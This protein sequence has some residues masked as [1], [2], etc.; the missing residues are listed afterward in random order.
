MVFYSLIFC[1]IDLLS[2]GLLLFNLLVYLSWNCNNQKE[3]KN[4]CPQN[5]FT[6]E[7][8]YKLESGFHYQSFWFICCY[9]VHPTPSI[10]KCSRLPMSLFLVI[11]SRLAWYSPRITS[12]APKSPVPS[13]SP[14]YFIHIRDCKMKCIYLM[15]PYQKKWIMLK[16]ENQS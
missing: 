9:H 14:I 13:I 10:R 5:H 4:S 15:K 7:N 1:S 3:R 8:L 11:Y 6:S 16:T 2:F 12:M